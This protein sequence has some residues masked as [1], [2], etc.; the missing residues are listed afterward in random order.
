MG[1]HYKSVPLSFHFFQKA[2]R[3][4]SARFT[5]N[6]SFSHWG[7]IG[8]LGELINVRKPHKVRFSCHGTFNLSLHF[9]LDHLDS[10]GPYVR[11]LF[12]DFSA[13]NTIIPER[14][15]GKMSLIG[16]EPSICRWIMDFLTNRQEPV[17]QVHQHRS[18]TGVRAVTISL[19]T[20]HQ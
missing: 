11:M 1:S 4:P 5:P 3:I 14:L 9:V 20:V 12:V 18:T 13:F 10:P 15:Q 2:S 8:R 16:V 7:T 6:A 17:R 19:L